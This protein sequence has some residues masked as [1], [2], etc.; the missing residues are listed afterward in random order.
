M[1]SYT[2]SREVV[3]PAIHSFIKVSLLKSS[4]KEGQRTFTSKRNMKLA[5][6]KRSKSS[7]CISSSKAAN[8]A[9]ENFN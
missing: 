2:P 3:Q 1:I 7:I 4:K 9:Y 6:G 8:M 5:K